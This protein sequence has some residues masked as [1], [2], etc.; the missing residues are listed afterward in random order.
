LKAKNNRKALYILPVLP[1]LLKLLSII[2]E[3]KGV[4]F[5]RESIMLKLRGIYYLEINI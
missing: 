5:P 3:I 4:A 1:K 2:N